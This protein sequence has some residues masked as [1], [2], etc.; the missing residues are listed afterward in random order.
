VRSAGVSFSNEIMKLDYGKDYVNRH[1]FYSPYNPEPHF[2]NDKYPVTKFE[3]GRSA[4][5]SLI[6]LNSRDRDFEVYPQPTDLVLRLPRVYRNIVNLQFSQIRLLCSFYYFRADKANIKFFVN[7]KERILPNRNPSDPEGFPIIINPGSYDINSLISQLNL[8]LNL[9]PLFYDFPGGFQQFAFKFNS[10]GDLALNFNEVG[11]YFFDILHGTYVSPPTLTKSYVTQTFFANRYANKTTFTIGE[12]QIAYYYPVLKYALLLNYNDTNLA[13]ISDTNKQYVLYSFRGLNDT[14]L[15]NIV[16]PHISYLDTFRDLHTFKYALVNKY[17]VSYDTTYN[18]I[19]MTTPNLNSSLVN[20]LTSQYN[21]YFNAALLANNI[22]AAQYGTSNNTL[23]YYN[24]ALLSMYDYLQQQLAKVFAVNYGTYTVDYLATPDYQIFVRDGTNASNIQ[25]TFSLVSLQSRPSPINTFSLQVTPPRNYWPTLNTGNP[26]SNTSSYINSNLNLNKFYSVREEKFFSQEFVSPSTSNINID[27]RTHSANILVPVS[28]EKYTIIA[29]KSIVNQTL[30]VETMSRP[31]KYRYPAYNALNYSSNISNAFNY[32]YEYINNTNFEQPIDVSIPVNKRIWDSNITVIGPTTYGITHSNPTLICSGFTYLKQLI[33]SFQAPVVSTSTPQEIQKYSVTASFGSNFPNNTYLFMYHDRAA[34]MADLGRPY[35]E[36][37]FHYKQSNAVDKNTNNNLSITW[38]VYEG[39]IY[40]FILRPDT[41]VFSI[42]NTY[43]TITFSEAQPIVFTKN[44]YGFDPTINP[45]QLIN[46]GLNFNYAS[47]YDPDYIRLPISSDLWGYSPDNN[48]NNG[49]IPHDGPAIGYDVNGYSTDLTDYRP[50]SQY[51]HETSLSFNNYY[52]PISSNGATFLNNSSYNTILQTYFDSNTKNVLQIAPLYNTYT[53][54]VVQNR[55]YKIV[56]W[57]DS[58]FIGPSISQNVINIDEAQYPPK[59]PFVDTSTAGPIGGYIYD[60]NNELSLMDGVCGFTFLPEDGIWNIRSLTFNSALMR[61]LTNQNS[62]IKYIG[63]YNT[64]DINNTDSYRL[65]LS[66]AIV[67]LVLTQRRYYLPDQTGNNN[68]STEFNTRDPLIDSYIFSDSHSQNGSYY[69]FTALSSNSISGYTQNARIFLNQPEYLCSAIAFDE[70]EKVTQIDQLTGSIVPF[71]D[72]SVTPTAA[73]TY[74]DG[75]RPLNNKQVIVPAPLSNKADPNY[76]TLPYGYDITQVQYEQSMAITTTALHYLN[77]KNPINDDVGFKTWTNTFQRPPVSI[78]ANIVDYLVTLDSYFKIFTYTRYGLRNLSNFANITIDEIFPIGDGIY[79]AAY[80][81][82]N[83]M[84]YQVNPPGQSSYSPIPTTQGIIFMGVSSND[85]QTN[86]LNFK[87]YSIDSGEIYTVPTNITH[88]ISSNETV[89]NFQ[90]FT[91]AT[92]QIEI[93]RVP[94]GIYSTQNR[95]TSNYSLY[96]T[97]NVLSNQFTSL[98]LSEFGPGISSNVPLYFNLDS[99]DK[100]KLYIQSSTNIVE[101]NLARFFNSAT[102]DDYSYTNYTIN[103]PTNTSNY[104][105]FVNMTFGADRTY[106][107]LAENNGNYC[108]GQVYLNATANVK[109]S[110]QTFTKPIASLAT[111]STYGARWLV[112]NDAPYIYSYRYKSDGTINTAWQIFYPSTKITFN[113]IGNAKQPIT[114]LTNIEPPE[115]FHTNMFVYN[116]ISNLLADIGSN[117]GNEQSSNYLVSDTQFRGFQFNSYIPN[118]PLQADKTYYLAIRGYTPSEQF[119]TMVRFY[120]PNRYDYRSVSLSDMANETSIVRN[121]FTS[122]N[123]IT[124]Y[125]FNPLYAFSLINFDN[126]FTGNRTYGANIIPSFAG[127][128]HNTNPTSTYYKIWLSNTTFYSSNTTTT[129]SSSSTADGDSTST[130]TTTTVVTRITR[131]GSRQSS[132]NLTITSGWQGFADFYDQFVYIYNQYTALNRLITN[133][134]NNALS[135][136]NQFII[137]DLQNI[138]PQ[139]A[140]LRQNYNDPLLFSLLF[141][142]GNNPIIG[143]QLDNWG[144]GWNLGYPK[145]DTVY[146]TIARGNTFFK[147]LDDYV[148]VRLNDEFNMNKLDISGKENLA[149]SREP[150]GGVNQ[151]N[152]KLFLT[153]FGGYA[154]TAIMNP[155]SFNPP[156]GKLDKFSFTLTDTAG[157][158]IDNKDCDWNATLQ[159]TEMLDTATQSSTFINLKP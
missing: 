51:S 64:G 26:L 84:L 13:S 136:I 57:Y 102:L 144:I 149:E 10:T 94:Y 31:L 34:L 71:P 99:D 49:S 73:N 147:I 80:A 42:F 56:N 70:N 24:A 40:Y 44:V 15:L 79:L 63:I 146:S 14:Y 4:V 86:K 113:K 36:I 48:S 90:Q 122:N 82:N 7:E 153:T 156:I 27:V 97:P 112:G 37:R 159:I 52:D 23:Q 121:Y 158:I 104:R 114:D 152:T 139:S 135:N 75:N 115:Y 123:G 119:Q 38:N 77:I 59:E 32:K 18:I 101:F 93:P 76:K 19:T 65:S 3:T 154:Q 17:V 137:T 133:I 28:A 20:L 151:Y 22:T 39:E 55:E 130:T 124:P 142:S 60:Q 2:S 105:N 9:Y 110:S 33:F 29:F 89:L 6:L 91:Y 108:W 132:G 118:V 58:I 35:N 87:I 96:V 66:N 141:K 68:F 103:G 140:L 72:Y 109:L 100:T 150:T 125:T 92:G 145:E 129:G 62:N 83:N 117:W 11:D 131:S 138:L 61:K 155:I 74:F 1:L 81:T 120:M 21:S 5:Q 95:V 12:M 98:N 41:P 128:T 67:K 157:N 88:T 78:S 111:N 53:P 25:T 134:N 43:P 30:E 8:Q 106:Y 54:G 47:I 16:I 148:Y 126:Y 45:T 107:I 46:F 116:N 50:F 127:I 69:T 143:K 85:S